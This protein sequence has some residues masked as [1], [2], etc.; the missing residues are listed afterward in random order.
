MNV[1]TTRGLELRGILDSSAVS[2]DIV[3]MPLPNAK[4][5]SYAYQLLLT[6]LRQVSTALQMALL[7]CCVTCQN[8]E[9]TCRANPVMTAVVF[10]AGPVRPASG[11]CWTAGMSHGPL[12]A[13]FHGPPDVLHPYPTMSYATRSWPSSKNTFHWRRPCPVFLSWLAWPHG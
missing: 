1:I 10:V 12:P 6:S 2:L 5:S 7:N 11:D 13:L 8:S 4:Y 9:I 3:A